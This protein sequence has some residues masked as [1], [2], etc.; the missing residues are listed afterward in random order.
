MRWLFVGFKFNVVTF[1]VED[2]AEDDEGR[3]KLIQ[4]KTT[5]KPF[6]KF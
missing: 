6:D 4:S 5:A 3:V 1:F 2:F